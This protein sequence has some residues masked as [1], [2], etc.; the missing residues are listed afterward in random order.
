MN[1]K[2]PIATLLN[3]LICTTVLISV[4][5]VTNRSNAQAYQPPTTFLGPIYYGEKLILNVF[6]HD[7]PLFKPADDGN[8]Y[9]MHYDGTPYPVETPYYGYDQHLGVDYNLKYEPVLAAADGDVAF[10]GWS[11]PSDHRKLYG[12]NAQIIHDANSNYRVWYGHLSVLTVQ[13]GEEVNVDPANREGIIGIS[14]NTGSVLGDCPPVYENPLCGAHLH[15]EVRINGKPANPYGW[16]GTFSDPWSVY[17][18]PTVTTMPGTPTPTPGTP[19]PAGATSY[20][21]W[22]QYPARVADP[23]QYPDGPTVIEPAAPIAL[24]TID[25]ND[26]EYSTIP[27]GCMTESDDAG[28]NGSF[29]YTITTDTIGGGFGSACNAR[30]QITPNAYT[31]PGYYDVYVHIPGTLY[32]STLSAEYKIYHN[33]QTHTSIVVQAAYPNSDHP[34][35][36][37]YIGRHFFNMGGSGNEYILMRNATI[38]DDASHLIAADAVQFARVGGPAVTATPFHTVTAT[39]SP[40]PQMTIPV[41]QSSDDAGPR[42]AVPTPC[43]TSD[44]RYATNWNEVYLGHCNDGTNIVSGFRFTNVAVPPG[45][46]ITKAQIEFTVDGTYTQTHTINVQFR[47]ELTPNSSTFD[48]MIRPDNRP[49]TQ[50]TVLWNISATDDWYVNQKRYSPNLKN[51]IQEIVNQSAWQHGNA[52]TIIVQPQPGIP[53]NN[54]RRVFAIEREGMVKAAK[55]QIWYTTPTNTGFKSPSANFAENTGDGNG[56]EVNPTGAYA[57]GGGVGGYA[58]DNDS[59]TSTVA[60][61]TAITKDRHRYYNFSGFSIPTGATITGI[62]VRLDAKVD[63]TTGSP[64][65]CV[66]LSR[67]G[68]STWTAPKETPFLVTTEQNYLLG[69]PTD[70]WGT[71]WIPGSFSSAN[72]RVRIVNVAS[73]NMR[74]FS[75]DWVAV[76]VYYIP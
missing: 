41:T 23:A 54:H 44:I 26:S 65:M 37:V 35:H 38:A 63:S 61:C 3:S 42:G 18:Q 52:L 58:I 46:V 21:L 39:P 9:T 40:T 70:K 47:G 64:Y 43:S 62:E 16:I 36:W 76:N 7:L 22:L 66:L 4:F 17:M 13:T 74:D 60:S 1:K 45:A 10:A 24:R 49:L 30:W 75:L 71:L 14:G 51:I 67:D 57:D 56:F 19:T 15:I 69:G 34:D 27:S 53:P 72:F 20:D 68:G 50:A 28:I 31:T 33:G 73:S 55:L 12:L 11:E 6:D 59:G 29:D 5:L 2:E 32:P 8:T 48:N 25:D